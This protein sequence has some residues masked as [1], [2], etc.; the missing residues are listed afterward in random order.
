MNVGEVRI[1][2]DSDFALLKV[3][4]PLLK[5]ALLLYLE[6]N[7]SFF[8][9]NSILRLAVVYTLH[10]ESIFGEIFTEKWQNKTIQLTRKEELM[11]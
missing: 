11:Q 4:F 1:A 8:W 3:G 5:C 2:E 9:N 6:K 7:A 10:S